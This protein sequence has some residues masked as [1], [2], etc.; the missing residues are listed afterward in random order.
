MAAIV[1]DPRRPGLNI[2]R[3]KGRPGVWEAYG[4]RSVRLTFERH[5]DLIIFRNNCRHDIID[6]GDV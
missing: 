2:H 3:Y 5:G 1:D 6:G 4:S